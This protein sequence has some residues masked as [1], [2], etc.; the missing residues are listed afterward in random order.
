MRDLLHTSSQK[1]VDRLINKVMETPLSEFKIEVITN[2]ADRLANHLY[3]LFDVPATEVF[4]QE[5]YTLIDV[6][7]K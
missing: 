1:V 7:E 2:N 5:I 6:K 3:L 4:M